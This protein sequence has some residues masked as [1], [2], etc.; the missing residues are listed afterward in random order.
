MKQIV[1][2]QYICVVKEAQWSTNEQSDLPKILAMICIILNYYFV[3]MEKKQSI[4]F[5]I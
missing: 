1:L 3:N 4:Y 5:I 2:V